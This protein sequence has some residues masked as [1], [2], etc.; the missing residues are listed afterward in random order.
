M[1]PVPFLVVA[2]AGFLGCFS[3]GPIYLMEFG[4]SLP[5]ALGLSTVA[6]CATTAL[7]YH[8]FVWTAYPDLRSEIP[9]GVRLRRL[10]LGGLA[11]AGVFV[12]LSLPLLGRL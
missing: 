6:C 5:G 4:A 8:R 1:D 9:A 12:L 11:V 3:C 7:D 10:L 2:A